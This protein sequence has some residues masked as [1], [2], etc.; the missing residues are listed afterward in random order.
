MSETPQW[1]LK[2]A[3]EECMI[4]LALHGRNP[5]SGG[6]VDRLPPHLCSSR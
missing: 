6:P 5:L 2:E 4:N 3:L 1:P